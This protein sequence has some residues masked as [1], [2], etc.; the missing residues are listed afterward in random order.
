MEYD[1]NGS[2]FFQADCDLKKSENLV[3][4]G[5]NMK[6]GSMFAALEKY[7]SE[8]FY[9]EHPEILFD[10]LEETGRYQVAA[11]FKIPGAQ[12]T[13]AFAGTL[14]AA[15]EEDYNA[16]IAY[17]KEHS[18]YDTGVTPQ[19]PEQLLTLGTCEYTYEDGRLFV[20][21]R[22]VPALK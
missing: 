16:F 18:L 9:R 3:I 21:G 4:Y 11:V 5:H 12:I 13:E 1:A 19:W 10:T 15:T 7:T 20:V 14:L 8:E 22:A 2:L 17:A 6:N